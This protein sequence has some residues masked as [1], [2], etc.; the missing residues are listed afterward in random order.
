[1]KGSEQA[2]P[3][4]LSKA[5]RQARRL[6]SPGSSISAGRGNSRRGGG[7][8][9][10]YTPSARTPV[11][12]GSSRSNGTTRACNVT[13]PVPPART[14]NRE[15]A[16]AYNSP[17]LLMPLSWIGCPNPLRHF[18]GNG[19]NSQRGWSAARSDRSAEPAIG[20]S[21][22]SSETSTSRCSPHRSISLR[23]QLTDPASARTELRS[24]SSVS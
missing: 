14:V 22:A 9:C 1:M 20:S 4:A 18:S 15:A 3:G 12:V 2:N 24:R 17:L 16:A 6:A 23:C 21:G 19:E 5:A 13:R 10:S 8:A 11:A 7:G